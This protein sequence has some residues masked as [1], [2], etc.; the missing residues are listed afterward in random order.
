[1]RK[2]L[3]ALMLCIT[4]ICYA[5]ECSHMK[6]MGI[7]MEGSVQQFVSK[8]KAKGLTY[9]TT[10]DGISLLKGEFATVKDCIVGV[11]KMVDADKVNMVVVMFPGKENWGTLSKDYYNLK[12]MLA[13]KY[14]EP[15]SIENFGKNEEYLNDLI[16]FHKILDSEATFMSEYTCN[17][18]RVQLSMAK[19][20][21]SKCSLIIRYIDEANASETRQRIMDDL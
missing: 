2:I 3:I 9:M 21:F 8:L 4:S 15:Q 14:G 10:S 13:E 11:T 6:F 18:G 5:Q 16:K 17:N 7:P 1:M 19:N 12:E 20:D